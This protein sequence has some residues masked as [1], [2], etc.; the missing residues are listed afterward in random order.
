LIRSGVLKGASSD[1]H[2]N[3]RGKRSAHASPL[4]TVRTMTSTPDAI[5]SPCMPTVHHG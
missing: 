1:P 4:C 2:A 5:S 3:N